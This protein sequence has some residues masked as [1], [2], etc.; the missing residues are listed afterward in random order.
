MGGR[1]SCGAARITNPLRLTHRPAINNKRCDFFPFFPFFPSSLRAS[2]SSRDQF[3]LP[4]PHEQPT[5]AILLLKREGD[6]PAEPHEL[7]D[8]ASSLSAK[9]SNVLQRLS[10]QT[11]TGCALP[12]RLSPHGTGGRRS[13]GAAQTTNPLRLPTDSQ[14]PTN[15]APKPKHPKTSIPNPLRSQSSSLRAS[16]PSRD[17]TNNP[18]TTHTRRLKSR[19]TEIPSHAATAAKAFRPMERECDAPAEPH[20]QQTHSPH[21]PSCNQQQT[22]RLFSLLSFLPSRLRVFA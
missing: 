7:W 10:P 22:L 4:A 12:S 5:P 1:R 16:A 21:P 6:A 17:P 18:R 9:V 11:S 19:N 20:K 13:C 8:S 14:S 15:V 3:L 2:A